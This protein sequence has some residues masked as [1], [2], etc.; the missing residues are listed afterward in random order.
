MASMID[1]YIGRQPIFKQDLSLYAYELLFR[2]NHE[3]N[4]ANMVSGDS[5]SAQVML[6]AFGDIGLKDI[7]GN[8]KVF[9]NFTEGLLLREN[10]PFFPPNQIVIEVLEDVEVTPPLL[11]AI[12]ELRKLGYTIALDDYV[13]NPQLEQLEAYADLI[14]VD[15]LEVGPKKLA[16]HTKRLKAKG[17]RLLAEKVELR[18][19]YEFCKK[20]GFDYFQG[21]FF[22]RP[23]IIKGQ[24]LPSNKLTIIQLLASVYD[25]D[26]DM[27]HLSEIISRDVSLS[28]KL[29]KFLAENVNSTVPINSIHDGVVRFGLTRL[30]SWTSMLALSGLD[31]KP[32][33]LFRMALTRAKFCEIVG[34]KIGD[35]KADIYFTVGLFSTLDAVMDTPLT[36]LLNQ[37]KLDPQI[38]NA[39]IGDQPNNLKFTL[40]AVKG[41]ERG[42]TDFRLPD[43]LC[44]TELSHSYL[45]AM[46]FAQEVFKS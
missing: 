42:K 37:L 7:A 5:A 18:E 22:A 30:Q 40:E 41:F 39:L 46:Q 15:I 23:K 12:K 31:D 27:R 8:N 36:A 1:I 43:S 38:A 26:I 3:S 19:Q 24:R 16:E 28:Q 4:Y 34:V 14:K 44:P 25:P 20:I 17:V 21:Y 35:F 29:L 10:Q 6:H 33:E 45:E 11:R 2:T 13:F 9:I 32:I